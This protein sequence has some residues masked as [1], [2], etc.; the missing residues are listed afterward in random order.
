VRGTQYQEQLFV[1]DGVMIP[2]KYNGTDFT[3]HGI[4]PPNSGPTAT[5]TSAGVLTGDYRYKVTYVNSQ[6]VESDTNTTTATLTVAGATV[7]LTSIPV[8]PQSFGVAARRV[9]RTEAGG[10]TWKRLTEIAN[11]TTTVYADSTPDTLLGAAAPSDQGVPPIYSVIIY[12]ASRLFCNDTQN[13]GVL[14][15][16]EAG[17][18]HLFP[19]TNFL[20][21]GDASG[22][23][24]KGLSVYQNSVLV[25]CETSMWLVYMPSAD[26]NDW[27]QIRTKSAYGTL[28]PD[29]AVI[30]N[31]SVIVPVTQ[32][33][34][35][36]GF[37]KV[38]GD[39]IAPDV[40]LTTAGA[41]GSD[42][43]SQKIEPDMF[44]VKEGTLLN[45]VCGIAWKNK[46]WFA[47]PSGNTATENNKVFIFD[48]S[49]DQLVKSKEP[50]WFPQ[51]GFKPNCWTVYA[52][53]LYYG[54]ATAS[55]FVYRADTDT[56]SDDGTAINS[57]IWTK[58][59][60]GY[61]GHES[62]IKDFR[63][64]NCLVEN[65]GD[66]MMDIY[67]RVDSDKGAGNA[68]QLDLDPGSNLWNTMLWGGTWGG[69]NDEQDAQIYLGTA[70]GKR[71]QFKFTNR[72][73]VNSRFRVYNLSFTY[74]LRGAR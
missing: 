27:S 31:D 5:S 20:L 23:V 34:K 42:L 41:V 28:C 3:R 68:V 73:T 40:T 43:A 74:N 7:G 72:N 71:I 29:G 58:E 53:Y 11:N 19:S 46:A 4:Y 1:G 56:Y 64:L 45:N 51:S 18:P 70:K 17:D 35:F 12:H 16:S 10:A 69:G 61:A 14:W 38:V 8:A 26:P 57:Y 22:D 52:G 37:A 67:Y 30:A 2:M 39:A 49:Y 15:Y 54:S 32:N 13:P 48:F 47:L 60:A 21:I 25:I 44:D 65:A 9:Y 55:G 50:A 33:G 62:L 6:S 59:F 36:S 63:Q 24:I 66:W